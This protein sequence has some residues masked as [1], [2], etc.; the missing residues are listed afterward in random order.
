[1]KSPPFY[2]KKEQNIGYLCSQYNILFR[3]K[4]SENICFTLWRSK[5]VST[6]T[7]KA[8]QKREDAV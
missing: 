4:N 5:A 7:K 2:K 1:M 3:H 8:E 6:I